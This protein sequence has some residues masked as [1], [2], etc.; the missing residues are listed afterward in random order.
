MTTTAKAPLMRTSPL[1][2]LF[3]ALLLLAPGLVLAGGDLNPAGFSSWDM[4]VFGNANVMA[5]ILSAI[6]SMAS[7][8]GYSNLL[9]F[10]ATIG[11]LATGAAAGFNAAHTP[12]FFM[13][14][15]G[16]YL[17]CYM[18]VGING[19]GGI[20]ANITLQD[21]VT[22]GVQQV[23]NVP[24]IVGVPAAIISA[25]GHWLTQ[26]VET[27]FSMPD[28]LK[29]SSGG[30]N[31]ATA[32]VADTTKMQIQDPS[33]K[34]SLQT[35]VAD[36]VVPQLATQGAGAGFDFVR[37][38]DLWAAMSSTNQS[39]LTNIITTSGPT[40]TP[41]AD[42]YTALT[43]ALRAAVPDMINQ[44]AGAWAS[45][46]ALAFATERLSDAWTWTSGGVAADGAAQ[47]K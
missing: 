21:T 19:S 30:F 10:L 20:K 33:L 3:F 36:C 9:W 39:M 8:A 37:S 26:A 44:G 4:Y 38:P 32:L 35:Y 47:V 13:Y 16:A 34:W 23:T 40:V 15:I 43:A 17:V 18:A 7:S 24:A 46:G 29:S 11:V 22:G 14:L 28:T 25:T 12:K 42:A 27:N 5:S 31:L 45:T 2:A 41:C 6:S 1:A